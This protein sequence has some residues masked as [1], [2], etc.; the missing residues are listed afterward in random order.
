MITY[1]ILLFLKMYLVN[2]PGIIPIRH[3]ATV[4][5]G[6]IAYPRRTQPSRSATSPH[7]PPNTGP[8]KSDARIMGRFSKLIRML[9]PMFFFSTVSAMLSSSWEAGA[10]FIRIRRSACS[11][12]HMILMRWTRPVRAIILSQALP[13][14]SYPAEAMRRRCGS[15]MRAEQ[16]AP[17][18]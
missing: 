11:C 1:G 4:I 5:S 18:R 8:N 17:R 2:T 7:A 12:L 10:V 6:M 9:L 15:R 3:E 14:K 16:Y 13:V